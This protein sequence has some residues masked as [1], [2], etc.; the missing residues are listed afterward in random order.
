MLNSELF[1]YMTVSESD[2]LKNLESLWIWET[3]YWNRHLMSKISVTSSRRRYN[4]TALKTRNKPIHAIH[5]FS[6]VEQQPSAVFDSMISRLPTLLKITTTINVSFPLQLLNRDEYLKGID[7]YTSIIKAYASYVHT[8]TCRTAKR[9]VMKQPQ[10]A[11][12]SVYIDQADSARRASSKMMPVRSL[13]LC[14]WSLKQFGCNLPNWTLVHYLVFEWLGFYATFCSKDIREAYKSYYLLLS[15][16]WWLRK[17]HHHGKTRPKFRQTM[18]DQSYYSPESWAQ[19]LA[20]EQRSE[21]SG[22]ERSMPPKSSGQYA[23][24]IS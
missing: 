11:T 24:G 17:S 1:G 16:F 4:F 22:H 2:A 10:H 23:A 13:P 15:S 20:S 7:I 3:W 12:V 5:Q 8:N 21:S 18:Q 9:R 6:D 19:L 14:D